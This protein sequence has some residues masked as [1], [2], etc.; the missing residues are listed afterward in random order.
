MCTVS[1]FEGPRRRRAPP[2]PPGAVAVSPVPPARS[3]ARE[4]TSSGAKSVNDDG[5]FRLLAS[6]ASTPTA[7]R[8][9]NQACHFLETARHKLTLVEAFEPDERRKRLYRS[10]L[11]PGTDPRGLGWGPAKPPEVATEHGVRRLQA[12][13]TAEHSLHRNR[14]GPSPGSRLHRVPAIAPWAVRCRLC[15]R[16]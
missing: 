9:S 8:P 10:A 14:Y 2:T 11:P 13:C 15:L 5:S 6:P 3:T 4:R 12:H 16:R 7:T 1:S